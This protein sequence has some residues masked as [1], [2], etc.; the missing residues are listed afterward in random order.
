MADLARIKSNVAKMAA[1]NAPE[2]DIDGYIASE[3]VTIDDVRAFKAGAQPKAGRIGEDPVAAEKA[4]QDE[5]YSSGIY[6]GEYN[7]LGPIA[8][9]IGAG[10]RGI[11]R[12][13]FMGWDDEALAGVKTGGGMLGDYSEQQKLEDAK[14]RALRENNPIA[15]GVGELAGGL[16]AGGTLASAGLTTAGRSIPLLGRAGGAAVEGALYGG[17]TGA[18]EAKQGERA[19]GAGYGAALGAATGAVASK[20]GDALAGRAARKVAQQTAPSIDDLAAASNALYTQADQAGVALKPQTTDRLVNNMRFAAGELNDKLRPNTAGVVQDIESLRGQPITLKQFDELRQEIGLAMKNAQPQ[21]VRTLTRMKKI[22]DGFADNAG[23]GDVTGNVDGFQFIKDARQLW[24]KKAKTETIEDLFDLADV[25]SAKYSQSGMANAI[26]LRAKG[27]YT[28]IVKG[29][30]KGFT[31]EE[32]ALIRKLSKGELTPSVVNWLGKFAPRG[33]VSAGLGGGAGA[34]VGSLFGPAGAMIGA[35]A[36]GVV[37]YGAAAMADRAAAGGLAALRNA[38]AS[39]NAPV[40]G[41]ITN[42][43]VPFIG[44]TSGQMARELTRSR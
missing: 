7:P 19:Q 42:K 13:P 43:T 38:A 33:V 35:A 8:R 17:V 32:T 26:R 24:A 23:A 40:L 29:Q 44:A 27:L 9:S 1:Q 28:K 21:D 11:E 34:T 4:K 41:A 18:G 14:K 36:P 22:V 30:E 20:V 16:A 25:D 31:A 10:A 39:G 12:A 2:A 37:G 3:G 6:A 15:S 5:Y